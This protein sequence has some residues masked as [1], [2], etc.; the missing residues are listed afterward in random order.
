M[1]Y[2]KLNK[3]GDYSFGRGRA[4]FWRNVPDAVAQA[5]QTRLQLWVGQWYFN[6]LEGMPWQTR[7]LGKYTGDVRDAVIR[8]HILNTQGVTGIAAYS[9]SLNRDTRKFSAGTII[10]TEYGTIALQ[11]PK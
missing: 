9:S 1:M 3:A 4:D 7:V 2:R 6:T 10:D 5:V 11:G 8:E